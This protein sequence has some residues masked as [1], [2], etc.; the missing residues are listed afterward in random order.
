MGCPDYVTTYD[1]VTTRPP[2]LI[3]VFG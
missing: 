3:S 2:A 1:Y